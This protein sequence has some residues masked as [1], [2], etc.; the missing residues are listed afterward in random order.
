MRSVFSGESL[1]IVVENYL[2]DSL[3]SEVATRLLNA[4]AL[5]AYEVD[6]QIL[7]S[8]MTLFETQ[9][10]QHAIRDYLNGANARMNETRESFGELASPFDRIRCVLGE[11]WPPGAG[12]LRVAGR[13]S[14]F[15]LTRVLKPSGAIEP[16]QDVLHRDLPDH[17]EVRM[18]SQLAMNLYVQPAHAGG[19]LELWDWRPSDMDVLLHGPAQS[20]GFARESL[21]GDPLVIAPKTGMLVLFDA[22]KVHAVR[23]TVEGVRVAMSGF[24]GYRGED[25]PLAMW[26]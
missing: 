25:A 22:S 15:G 18:V 12:L 19:E 20:Y 13:P 1:A 7:R 10:N 3:C 6:P 11:I 17:P 9:G 14:F 24:V 4:P 21:P 26:S 8:S 16:H 5:A 2:P 23:K